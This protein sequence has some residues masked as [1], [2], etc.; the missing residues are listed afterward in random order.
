[1]KHKVAS[2]K[3]SFWIG[4]Q[5]G[6]KNVSITVGLPMFAYLLTNAKSWLPG[7]YAGIAG[8]LAALGAYMT[9]NFIENK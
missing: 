5:K 4:L 6:I 2:E 7:D 8:I 3:Y 1:M 9:K